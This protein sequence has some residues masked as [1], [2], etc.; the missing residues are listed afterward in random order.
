MLVSQR[1]NVDLELLLS[2]MLTYFFSPSSC[3][4]QCG[5]PF[6]KLDKKSEKKF[7]FARRQQLSQLIEQAQKQSNAG[8]LLDYTIIILFQ[9]V[10]QVVVCGNLLKGPI[11]DMLTEE[12][13]VPDE[14]SRLLRRVQKDLAEE[15]E[16]EDATLRDVVTCGLCKDISKLDTSTLS[17]L[18]A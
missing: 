16:I 6:K 13:K 12:R 17:S 1:R 11:L 4:S 18:Q 3:R 2:P 5:L 14:V 9:Q 15:N 8:A 10:K 7:L